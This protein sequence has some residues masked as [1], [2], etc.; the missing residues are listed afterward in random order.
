[1]QQ[2]NFEAQGGLVKNFLIRILLAAALILLTFAASQA[3][4]DD[5][6]SSS[7]IPRQ[8]GPANASHPAQ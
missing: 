3:Q 8:Q 4:R 1:L 7:V 2:F 5:E 6:N